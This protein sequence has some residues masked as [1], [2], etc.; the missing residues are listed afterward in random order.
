MIINKSNDYIKKNP[1]K[2]EFLAISNFEKLG[3]PNLIFFS[4]HFT[5][6]QNQPQHKS[7]R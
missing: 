5:E 6:N 2:A 3:T 4:H 1:L 7:K